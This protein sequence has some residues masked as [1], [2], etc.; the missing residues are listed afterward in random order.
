MVHLRIVVPVDRAGDALNMLEATPS[1][2][3]I[4]SLPGAGYMHGDL[5]A[6]REMIMHPTT[7]VG[8]ADAGV[9]PGSDRCNGMSG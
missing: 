2:C 8:L 1:V 4:I 5:E 7:I 3:N 6:T 9:F